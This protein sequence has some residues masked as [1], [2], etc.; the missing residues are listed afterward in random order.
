MPY[1]LQ[2][3]TYSYRKTELETFS[4][5]TAVASPWSPTVRQVL[6]SSACLTA[7]RLHHLILSEYFKKFILFAI[8]TEKQFS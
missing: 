5:G 7:I 8:N 6:Q 3:F 2:L 1:E 4:I